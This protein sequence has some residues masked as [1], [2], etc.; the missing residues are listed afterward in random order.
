MGAKKHLKTHS[1]FG[2]TYINAGCIAE[3]VE[4]KGDRVIL[5]RQNVGLNDSKRAVKQGLKLQGGNSLE[6]S[7]MGELSG[8]SSEEGGTWREGRAQELD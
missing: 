2:Y 7:R 8:L 3:V 6:E 5:L 4:G 1:Y